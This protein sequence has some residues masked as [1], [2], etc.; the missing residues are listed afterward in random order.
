MATA[1]PTS[2][3]HSIPV[4]GMTCAG[5]AARIER[6]L[7]AHPGVLSGH[8][9]LAN[10]TASVALTPEA[11]A[12][13]E[14]RPALAAAIRSLGYTTPDPDISS[15]PPVAQASLLDARLTVGIL[16]TVPVFIIAMATMS[17]GIPHDASAD[18]SPPVWSN[19]LQLILTT[20]VFF[21]T[22]WP[23]LVA[24][25][26]NARHLAATM[27]TL[28]S[29]GTAAAYAYSLLAVVAPHLITPSTSAA[30]PPVYFEAAA[31][32]LVLVS[33]G[34][35]LEA[36]ATRRAS[37]AIRALITLQPD[38][39]TIEQDG[40]LTSIP[41]RSLK[42][43]DT[44][45]IRPGERVPADAIISSGSSALD[46]SMLTG[47]SIPAERSPGSAIHAGT[48]NTTGSLRAR[49]AAAPG[50]TALDRIVRLVEEAQ[51]GKAPISRLADRISAVLV[52]IVLAIALATFALWL[53]L[54]PRDSA[55]SMA[56]LTSVS[57]L[58]I[59]CPC[60][61]GLATPTAI[62]VATGLGARRGILIANA[63]T[64]ELAH[65][66]ETVALDK[67][68]TLT[69][70]SPIVTEVLPLPHITASE[71]L[72][73][74]AVAE[75]ESEHPIARAIVAAALAQ[76]LP[77]YGGSNLTA[78]PGQGIEA[79]VT[80]RPVLIGT[81]SF[82]SSRGL[83]PASLVALADTAA[84]QGRTSVLIAV[85]WQPAGIITV[86][87]EIRPE[88]AE[89]IARLRAMNIRTVMLSGDNERTARAVAS[90]LGIDEVHAQVLPADKAAHIRTL[91]SGGRIV[92]MVGD[93]INDAPALAQADVGIAIGAGTDAAINASDITL[94]RSDPRAIA[95]A[96]AVSRCTMRTI[97]QNLFW[98]FVY[99]LIGI[100]I[101]AGLLYPF[102][103]WLLSPML[104]GLAMSLSSV[105]VVANSLR[106]RKAL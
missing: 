101:A 102:T 24:A 32:V 87:D 51:S 39:A 13:S 41:A 82:L 62:M 9:N 79:T 59:A 21:F 28:V 36:R 100:P 104:A 71:L 45:L 63:P 16:C 23:F 11:A 69:R 67:T 4:Q 29:L 47:E 33:L 88:S 55:L 74:A 98:A 85:D 64:L 44:I 97:R 70:G 72:R 12:D 37:D 52:P 86:A 43:G 26:T 84:A 30:H 27:D 49:V 99:N 95:D 34:K 83:N 1:P 57:V 50:D 40:S 90:A 42:S 80:G 54:A 5:C 96:I 61:L 103:G 46:E 10:S 8:V 17:H 77:L 20:P 78:I 73:I 22:G 89:A 56:L 76:A 68:G 25:W 81:S 66:I 53:L 105:S 2:I 31:V 48:L 65:K 19:W 75:Q 60:A 7:T 18:G 58:V 92:A 15:S 14:T 35:R 91:Q 3:R 94:M 6:A 106:L 93:G 38:T